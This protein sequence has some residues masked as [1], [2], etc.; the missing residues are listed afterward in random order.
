MHGLDQHLGN[1]L[2]QRRPLWLTQCRSCLGSLVRP[3]CTEMRG[4]TRRTSL[5][6]VTKASN[7]GL[8]SKIDSTYLMLL[9][10]GRGLAYVMSERK[11]AFPPT[12]RIRLDVG[13]RL[14]LYTTRGVF[15]SPS[16]DRGRV[17]GTAEVASPILP[18]EKER[19]IAGRSYTSGCDLSLTG[20]IPIGHG[21]VLADIVNQLE[22]FQPDPKTWSARMRRSVLRLPSHDYDLILTQLEPRLRNP[23]DVV[24]GYLERAVRKSG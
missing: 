6:T 18:L 14:L 12:R 20:L 15:G 17:V 19:F 8:V 22:V 13:D 2:G 23:N 5:T 4:P 3:P 7:V 16:A 21:V 9:A 1:G 24:Q 10:T 11:M